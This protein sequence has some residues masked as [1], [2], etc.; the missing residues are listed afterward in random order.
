MALENLSLS[1][2]YCLLCPIGSMY[3]IFSYIWLIFMV[4]V[5]K[6]TSPMD[7]MGVA[8][9]SRLCFSGSGHTL[10]WNFRGLVPGTRSCTVHGQSRSFLQRHRASLSIGGSKASDSK[11]DFCCFNLL[12]SN[13]V[14]VKLEGLGITVDE[15]SEML[16]LFFWV[17]I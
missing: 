1:I 6:Y 13:F 16:L 8:W 3:G 2:T 17:P 11:R 4:N 9:A 7:P 14:D 15:F 12:R 10:W 5:G